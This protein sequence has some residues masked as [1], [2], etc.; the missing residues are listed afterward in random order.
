MKREIIIALGGCALVV[1]CN[2]A[3]KNPNPGGF[4]LNGTINGMET[5][6]IYIGHSDSAGF[7]KDSAAIKGHMFTYMGKV[8]D[9]AAY[10]IW[11][12]EKDGMM[13]DQ[14]EFFVDDTVMQVNVNKDSLAKTTV[15]GSPAEDLF[16]AY[17]AKMQ[18][19]KDKKMAL[20]RAYEIAAS[21]N[22][23]ATMDSL[24]MAYEK[25]GKD[26]MD[27]TASYIQSNPN[28]VIGAWAVRRELYDLDTKELGKLYSAFSPAV[29]QTHY[30]QQIKKEY[31][32]ML[33]TEIGMMAPDF[34]MNDSTGKGVALSSFHGKY[35]LLDFWASWCGP[36][37]RENPN[38]VETYK[39]YKDKNFTILGVSLDENKASWEKA[40]A[41]DGLAWNHVSDLKGWSNAVAAEY[42]VKAIPTNYLLDPTGKI[43]A[44]NL[45]DDA[46]AD[47][48]AKYVK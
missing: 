17:N 1:A 6:W 3:P 15:T 35:V 32:V 47:T 5:G 12:H 20:N 26:Q 34:T 14:F 46:L 9:P 27:A 24:E 7:V 43:L 29:Q 40:I 22:N 44:H 39:K 18:P 8:A 30:G 4:T 25:L 16:V 23:K 37:R 42:G 10:Y 13:V 48:L 31:D 19:F 36:C 45:R 41:E 28:S 2:N 21:T 33:K 38:V 11:L